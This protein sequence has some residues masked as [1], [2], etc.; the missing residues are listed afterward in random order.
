MVLAHDDDIVK[1]KRIVL[2]IHDLL[3]V[4]VKLGCPGISETLAKH[5]PIIHLY[6]S[7]TIYQH[8]APQNSPIRDMTHG[9]KV[10]MRLVVFLE[11]LTLGAFCS[12]Q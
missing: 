12:T 1:G 10:E 6:S 4:V 11:L 2:F 7:S 3:D 9:A 8:E 5:H